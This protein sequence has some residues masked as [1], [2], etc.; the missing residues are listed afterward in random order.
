MRKQKTALLLLTTV[1]LVSLCCGV[2]YARY[3][4]RVAKPVQFQY[5]LTQDLTLLAQGEENSPAWLRS[6]NSVQL[7]FTVQCSADVE[8]CGFSLYLVAACDTDMEAMLQNVAVTLES[9]EQSYFGTLEQI[10]PG[11]GLYQQVGN[12]YIYRFFDESGKEIIWNVGSLQGRSL[13]FTLT[14][15]GMGA[16]TLLEIFA[17]QQR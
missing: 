14:A 4:T 5:K 10:Q 15:S 2:A 8:S 13:S 12:G 7:P 16:D 1:L 17:A 6:G 11:T 9:G 3:I